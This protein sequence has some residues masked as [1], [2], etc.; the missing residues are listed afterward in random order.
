MLD[1]WL[2]APEDLPIP[3]VRGGSVQIYTYALVKHLLNYK[4]LSITLVSPS[5]I[6]HDSCTKLPVPGYQH[7]LVSSKQGHYLKN[8]LNLVHKS[9]P[10]IVQIEN[11]PKFIQAIR[12]AS[13]ESKIILNMHS[14]TFVHP[15][16]I[17]HDAAVRSF[18][19]AD[20]IVCN[21]QYLKRRLQAQ[22]NHF[23]EEPRQ[24]VIYPGVDIQ[25]FVP[26]IR[27]SLHSPIRLLYVGRVIR[28]KGLHI[29][30]RSLPYLARE[31]INV[32]LTV[33]GRTPPW[34]ANYEKF[35]HNL[36]K[37]QPVRWKGFVDPNE[38]AKYYQ[39]ADVFICPSQKD[40]AFGLVNIEAMATGLP[41]IASKVGGI[42]ESVTEH[43]GI[44]VDEY[45][46]PSAFAQ[47]IMALVKTN[48]SWQVKSISARNRALQFLWT[49][50][51]DQFNQLYQTICT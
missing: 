44:I 9:K 39:R 6:L 36:A 21:S 34:E 28:Q 37:H 15:K 3:P 27:R 38:L 19:K 1:V 30:L 17:A 2:I 4:N 29:V 20:Q 7:I 16:R 49:N 14:T 42:T 32:H 10:N 43:G 48:E 11:R 41:V 18:F 26:P 50:T 47:A 31:R 5:S 25:S 45:Q 51:A 23:I 40:E 24:I 22:F 35:V 12:L 8:V 13:P 33:I 46:V